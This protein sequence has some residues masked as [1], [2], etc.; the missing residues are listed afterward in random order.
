MTQEIM[1]VSDL[2]EYTSLSES[3]WYKQRAHSCG[4]EFIRVGKEIRYRK[5]DV[6]KWM[7]RMK[8]ATEGRWPAN[9]EV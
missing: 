7:E 5:V 2:V 3:Y 8:V 4:P 9:V 1:T 6:D